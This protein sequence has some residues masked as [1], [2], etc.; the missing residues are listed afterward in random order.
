MSYTAESENNGVDKYKDDMASRRVSSHIPA[1]LRKKK[2]E[3]SYK[4]FIT[5]IGNPM[6]ALQK[7]MRSKSLS[8]LN[9]EK[10]EEEK[11][12]AEINSRY[13]EM[14]K[15]KAMLKEDEDSWK[16]KLQSWKNRRR[17]VT[18]DVRKRK[19]ERDN[20]E[21][22]AEEKAS[23]RRTK[24][25]NQ[26]VEEK[27]KRDRELANLNDRDEYEFVSPRSSEADMPVKIISK[28]SSQ[29]DS[30][31]SGDDE[32]FPS[33]PQHVQ[34]RSMSAITNNRTGST[35]TKDLFNE[36]R[37]EYKYTTKVTAQIGAPPSKAPQVEPQ[38]TEVTVPITSSP[39]PHPQ[40]K[41]QSLRQ[42]YDTTD[43]NLTSA[44]QTSN[45]PKVLLRSK[46]QRKERPKSA[47][48][49]MQGSSTLPRNYHYN[50][51]PKPFVAGANDFTRYRKTAFAN[52]RNMWESMGTSSTS[53]DQD[54]IHRKQS[55]EDLILSQSREE[56]NQHTVTVPRPLQNRPSQGRI[57][58]PQ[59]SVNQQNDQQPIKTHTAVQQKPLQAITQQ[60][61]LVYPTAKL[62]SSGLTLASPRFSKHSQPPPPTKQN[63]G[64]SQPAPLFDDMKICI[65][66]R[67]RSE[68]GFGFTVRGGDDGKPVIVDT[69][70]SGGAAD[71]C[72]LR[73]SDEILAINEVPLADCKTQDDIV[74]LIVSSVITGH[75]SL[76]I[77]RYG[78]LKKTSSLGLSGT[79]VVMT[80]GGF[81]S[82]RSDKTGSPL[83]SP[84]TYRKDNRT[85]NFKDD[86]NNNDLLNGIDDFPPPPSS[87]EL[88]VSSPL[89]DLSPRNVPTPPSHRNNPYG[90]FQEVYSNPSVDD[91]D[92]SLA[93]EVQEAQKALDFEQV[94]VNQNQYEK[95]QL[96]RKLIEEQNRLEQEEIQREKE[97]KKLQEEA[98]LEDER[99]QREL[100]RIQDRTQKQ[101][102][103]RRALQQQQQQQRRVQNPLPR[104][105]GA[106]RGGM[107]WLVEEAERQ[108]EA[109]SAGRMRMNALSQSKRGTAS[110]LPPHVIQHLTQRSTKAM[111]QSS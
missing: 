48:E 108:R 3:D 109:E 101:L 100:R 23:H 66:Q 55:S 27:R 8:D 25:Y 52:R 47:H 10:R 98:R 28:E 83:Y 74:Q 71:I 19:E 34:T 4:K 63:T 1:P 103:D 9:A 62:S 33:P 95:T 35:K 111:G 21:R 31:S 43:S 22:E 96:R 86:N 16:S 90:A 76:N 36:N 11:Q 20:L 68:K 38:R 42:N 41:L 91:D 75:L 106:S 110:V 14:E 105:N 24:T 97:R 102:Q 54:S 51:A 50:P 67:P 13:G 7:H 93:R 88:D 82:V 107:H 60:K 37:V 59:N 58:T 61:P 87:E 85:P 65:N 56:P 69:V 72:Q 30:E 92:D 80:A 94:N 5:P 78:K 49:L 64:S 79:K 40:G 2:N 12:R 77:R 45:V 73:V 44:S 81:V 29:Y 32:P 104:P 17:S 99:V 18:E 53:Q 39:S 84:K 70:S 26:I 46:G 57:V 15:L 89:S 6:A